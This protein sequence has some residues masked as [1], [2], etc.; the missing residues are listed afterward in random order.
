MKGKHK[1]Y[2]EV[3]QRTQESSSLSGY[4]LH[5]FDLY[6]YAWH[7]TFPLANSSLCR[8]TISL[9]ATSPF[10]ATC[11]VL[12]LY[13][14]SCKKHVFISWLQNMRYN[15]ACQHHYPSSAVNSCGSI[16]PP[17]AQCQRDCICVAGQPLA[18][19]WSQPATFTP[20]ILSRRGLH[21]SLPNW[22]W[23]IQAC[24]SANAPLRALLCFVE[25]RG[26]KATTNI[27]SA[28]Q[29]VRPSQWRR[30]GE[31]EQIKHS[32]FENECLSSGCFHAG[33]WHVFC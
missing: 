24:H 8:R 18:Q 11:L 31:H 26:I 20:T 1:V 4:E 17:P 5:S 32:L 19:F 6:Y 15:A 9:K 14:V 27:C 33:L 12:R 3:S 7:F 28:K 10:T 25:V 22:C 16:Y 2:T 30:N 23:S 13:Y 29:R 21:R